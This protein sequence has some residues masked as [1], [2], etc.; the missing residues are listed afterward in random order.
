MY[1]IGGFPRGGPALYHAGCAA[2]D[3]APALSVRVRLPRAGKTCCAHT[4]AAL[5]RAA[6]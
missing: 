4:L 6:S 3:A 1:L 2:A 5:A